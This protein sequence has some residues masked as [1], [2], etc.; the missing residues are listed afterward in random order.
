MF[1]TWFFLAPA[2]ITKPVFRSKSPHGIP[3]M[4]KCS[5]L[6]TLKSWIRN[7]E[8]LPANRLEVFGAKWQKSK[9]ISRNLTLQKFI[10]QSYVIQK[11]LHRLKEIWKEIP[12]NR[13]WS[14]SW[15]VTFV[16]QVNKESRPLAVRWWLHMS[17]P[18][19]GSRRCFFQFRRRPSNTLKSTSQ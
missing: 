12:W 7:V 11:T 15:L 2:R 4:D 9:D 10:Q 1:F 3:D 16:H 14:Y 19:I 18:F 13:S 5:E 8:G 17:S 6:L